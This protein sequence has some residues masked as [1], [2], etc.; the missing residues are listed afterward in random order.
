MCF[1]CILLSKVNT[2]YKLI[3]YFIVIESFSQKYIIELTHLS[4]LIF[5]LFLIIL[6]S[7]I[8]CLIDI[9][10]SFFSSFVIKVS[11]SFQFSLL[12][13]QPIFFV[14]AFH[15]F[16]VFHVVCE[17]NC[18]KR[19]EHFVLS[20]LVFLNQFLNSS[21]HKVSFITS[22]AFDQSCL[23][24]VGW[25]TL[26]HFKLSFFFGRLSIE[27]IVGRNFFYLIEASISNSFVHF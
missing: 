27:H 10:F 1:S 9:L 16:P 23:E 22:M 11:L 2:F 13:E 15:V 6:E 25:I 21:F 3:S 26:H 17:L 24:L 19:L 5:S 14:F 4:V 8:S 18:L 12:L 7:I 20:F